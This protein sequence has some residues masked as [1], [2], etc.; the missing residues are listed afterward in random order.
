M[1]DNL[2]A[3]SISAGLSPTEKKIFAKL[4]FYSETC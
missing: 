3:A 2:K 1:A 4:I